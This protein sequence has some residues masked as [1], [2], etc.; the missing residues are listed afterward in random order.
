MSTPISVTGRVLMATR[1]IRRTKYCG[2]TA[3]VV[4]RSARQTSGSEGLRSNPAT[5]FPRCGR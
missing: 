1:N 3:E 2:S 4:P 5:E